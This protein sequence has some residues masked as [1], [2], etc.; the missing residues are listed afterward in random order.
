[1]PRKVTPPGADELSCGTAPA[2]GQQG[3]AG[4]VHVPALSGSTG[5]Y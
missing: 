5:L 3:E 2:A 4:I 1:M